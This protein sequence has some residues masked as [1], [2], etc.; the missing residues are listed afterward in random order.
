MPADDEERQRFREYF[1]ARREAVRRTAYLLCGDWHWAD[2]LTQTAFVRLAARWHQVR[3]PGAL[4]AYLHTCLLRSYLAEARRLWRRR[5]RSVAQV[6]DALG[7][8]DGTE[9]ITRQLVVARALRELS[10]RQ[11]ATLIYR[12]YQQ[13]G[14]ADTA[15]VMGCSEGTVKS[16]TSRGLASLRVALVAAGLDELAGLVA[17]GE[18]QL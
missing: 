5:E 14:V 10:A 8:E 11:R 2:D 6:P 7:A 12:F 13:L 1:V 9:A 17:G 16:Q 3:D 18:V 4:D 15:A